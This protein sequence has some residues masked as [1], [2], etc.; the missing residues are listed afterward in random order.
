MTSFVFHTT[1]PYLVTCSCAI[2]RQS[3]LL[4]I[5]SQ[6]LHGTSSNFFNPVLPYSLSAL[7]N[8]S[9]DS[10]VTVL[11]PDG[12]HLFGHKDILS[13]VP[14]FRDTFAGS[15]TVSQHMSN[16]TISCR[17]SSVARNLCLTRPNTPTSTL[18]PS[19]RWS[20]AS[21]TT[22]LKLLYTHPVDSA[23]ST[24]N[25]PKEFKPLYEI[26]TQYQVPLVLRAID[27]YLHRDLEAQFASSPAGRARSCSSYKY[28][29][30][31]TWY[32]ISALFYRKSILGGLAMQEQADGRLR[33]WYQGLMTQVLEVLS[34]VRDE[35]PGLAE[36]DRA[37]LEREYPLLA[38]KLRT[39]VE[40]PGVVGLDE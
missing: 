4:M 18:R 21:W 23:L 36:E 13:T 8:S 6:N 40:W 35:W 14:N 33:M 20:P 19:N 17:S 26:A 30:A 37:R 9:I 34:R 7:F 12:T 16:F 1:I 38:E 32:F 10:D 5:N 25:H 15:P 29:S 2:E 24:P 22:F 39:G 3:N 28:I 31:R 11:L 27:G